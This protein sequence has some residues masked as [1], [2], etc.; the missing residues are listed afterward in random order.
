[1]HHILIRH[2]LEVQNKNI[3]GLNISGTM[4]CINELLDHII[5]IHI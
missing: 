1:M 3:K 2:K 5:Y 4:R